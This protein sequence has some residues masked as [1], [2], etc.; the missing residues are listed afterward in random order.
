MTPTGYYRHAGPAG[1]QEWIEDARSIPATPGS[2]GAGYGSTKPSPVEMLQWVLGVR[3]DPTPSE[4]A[5]NAAHVIAT[6][7]PMEIPR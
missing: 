3:S 4:D 1:E 7:K 6:T 2:G 5:A